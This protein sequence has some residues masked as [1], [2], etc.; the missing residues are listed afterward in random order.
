MGKVPGPTVRR[1]REKSPTMVWDHINRGTAWLYGLVIRSPIG[2]LMNGYR[3]ADEAFAKGRRYPGRHRC[4]PMSPARLFLSE[5]V[6]GGRTVALL[7]ACL[8]MLFACPLIAYGLFGLCAGFC[9]ASLYFVMPYIRE[10]MTPSLTYTA[11]SGSLAVLSLPLVFSA[12]S[13]S[14][15]LGDSAP[16]RLILVRLLGVPRDRLSPPKRKAPAGMPYL[17]AL[18]GVAAGIAT[19]WVHPA[20]IPA[21]LLI[22]GVLGLILSNP[23]AGVVLSTLSLPVIWLDR[24]LLYLPVLLILLTWIS[25]GLKLLS[26]HRTIRFGLL[27]MVVLIFGGMMLISGFT[28][29]VVTADTVMRSVLL[30]VCLSDYFLIVNLMTTREYI[31]RCLVGVFI[32]V[33]FVI[34]LSYLR[35]IPVDDLGWLEGSRAGNYLVDTIHAGIEHLSGLW[36]EHSEL[37]LVLTFPWLYAYLLHTRRV[38]RKV[39]GLISIGLALA[40]IIMTS[41]VSALLSVVCVTVLFF[42]LLGHKWLAVGVV[43]LPALGVGGWWVARLYPMSDAL[44][45]ILSRSRLF[46]LQLWDSLWHIVWD[47]PGGIGVGGDAFAAVYPFYAAPDLGA[48]TDSG[49]I[50]FEILLSYGWGGIILVAAMLFLFLQK[51]MTCL[52]HTS[53]TKDR[54]MI[55]GGV[56]SLVGAMVFGTVRSF[57]TAPRVFF[58]LLLVLALCSAY[59]NIIFDESD[60]LTADRAGSPLGEDRIY[61]RG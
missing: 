9:G 33:F 41:S 10:S 5:A 12:K 58:T 1:S 24:N 2:K 23:E 29:A 46:K 15:A 49:S 59:E 48:V 26:L 30:F 51:S 52:G 34:V 36:V 42:L 7:R 21:A 35:I 37:F 61:R 3:R 53:A 4:T 16:G 40:L 50:F 60:V 25:Y 55:L 54:A 13:L 22:L 44:S 6:E 19:L 31:R 18:L 47:H 14:E 56:T 45:T 27:D 39:T 17:M 38:F 8:Q 20:L 43:S 57:I 11:L 32:S 28:G